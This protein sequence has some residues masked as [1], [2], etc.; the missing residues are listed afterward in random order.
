M[1]TLDQQPLREV[2]DPPRCA[3]PRLPLR[4]QLLLALL[5]RQLRGERRLHGEDGVEGRARAAEAGGRG[6]QRARLLLRVALGEGALAVL[7]ACARQALGAR[8]ARR[9]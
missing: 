4:A 5:V 9:A 8:G 3:Q 2:I 7:E 6:D 1:A